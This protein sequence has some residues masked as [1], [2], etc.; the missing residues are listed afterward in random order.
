M[1]RLS[2]YMKVY[3]VG[4]IVDVAVNGAVQKGMPHKYYH[5]KTGIVYNV[6]K[7]SVGVIF[8]KVV[9]N[10]YLEKRVSVRVEH[11]KHSKCRDDFLRRVKEN[12]R[13]QKEAK[14]NGETVQL[15]RLPAAPREARTIKTES[16]PVETLHAAAYG[17]DKHETLQGT[18]ADLSQKPR[19]RELKTYL[20]AS[21]I[22]G[23]CSFSAMVRITLTQSQYR[24]DWRVC[25]CRVISSSSLHSLGRISTP[26]CE[27]IAVSASL[28]DW[29]FVPAFVP[30]EHI[31]PQNLTPKSIRS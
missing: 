17:K 1:I 20:P 30:V 5:G 3:K 13:K 31:V 27:S 11:V 21:C 4:D 19:S 28:I 8:Y 7:S 29:A 10:R 14:A 15:K 24:S 25:D 16:N 6:T 2:T 18:T 23:G 9:G 22:V 26:Q 12:A